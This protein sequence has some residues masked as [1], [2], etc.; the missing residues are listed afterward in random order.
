VGSV[1]S[2][3]MIQYVWHAQGHHGVHR[4][5]VVVYSITRARYADTMRVK[6]WSGDSPSKAAHISV[7]CARC[8][9]KHNLLAAQGWFVIH[10]CK[11]S[12]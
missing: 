10:S 12:R 6:S 8:C 2:W 7:L 3:F 11:S 9:S 5:L 4:M 1:T